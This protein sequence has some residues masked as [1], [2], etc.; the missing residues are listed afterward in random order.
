MNP[1]SA[2]SLLLLVGLIQFWLMPAL[3]WVLLKG[4]R[5]TAA[6]FWFAGTAC[7]A[8]TVSLFVVQTILPST[9]H[10]ILSF[11]LVTLMLMLMAES[12]RRELRRGPTPWGW[13]AVLPTVNAALLVPLHHELG[14][15]VA[16]AVQLGIISALD[17]GCCALL[18]AVIR[19]KKSRALVFV[20]VAFLVVVITNLL[21][22]YAFVAQ[23]EPPQLLNFTI[24]SNLGFLAN[25]LSVVV[26]SL[27]YWGFV[28]E[29]SR[30]ALWTEATERARAQQGELLAM[31][32]ERS[33]LEVVRQREELIGQLVKMQ[34]AAQAGALSASI[35]HEI[36]QPLAS[37]RLG[38]EEA[39][40][41]QK[42]DPGSDRLA[43]LLQRIAEEN[44]RAAGIIRTLRTLF[45]GYQAQAETRTVDEVILATVDL[46]KARAK[47]LKIELRLELA[48]ATPVSLGAG[49]LDQVM[50]NLIS[51][52]LD[53]LATA[54][55]PQGQVL[56]SSQADASEVVIQVS[57]NGSGISPEIHEQLFD[58]FA[59][60]RAEGIGLG[61]W[62]SRHIVERQGGSI[63]ARSGVPGAAF[64][65]RLPRADARAEGPTA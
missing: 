49:E 7:Y 19:Q 29:K 14:A 28:I 38:A 56:V 8:L 10:L 9:A 36:N 27:G 35:A 44:K 55:T 63:S 52:A 32:R 18:A 46:V 40:M 16:R 31:E 24:S 59:T 61:L 43:L 51:N 42:S 48:A 65:V 33:T 20:L 54:A 26:Y 15:D 39:L 4:Q 58:L 50:L 11:A 5:D 3:A 41:L 13:I 60:S 45:G 25:Y 22:V 57:D 64:T 53:S 37:V 12:L 62:L 2:L 21:R 47:D 6:R 1:N 30:T 23:G 17:L 34:R